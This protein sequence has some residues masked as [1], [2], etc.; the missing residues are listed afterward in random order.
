MSKTKPVH[1]VRIGPIKATIWEN[2]AGEGTRHNVTLSRL[3]KEGNEWRS[4]ESF[5]REDLLLIAKV[6]DQAHSW[7]YEHPPAKEPASSASPGSG[8]SPAPPSKA[9][10]GTNAGYRR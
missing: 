2:N 1:E 8:N 9:A 5:G 3:Y 10:V 4:S 6:A 7:I